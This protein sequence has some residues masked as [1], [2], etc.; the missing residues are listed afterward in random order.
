[1]IAWG[2]ED[3]PGWVATDA[4]RALEIARLSEDAG[5]IPILRERLRV[6]IDRGND[7]SPVIEAILLC[8]GDLARD[9]A[10]TPEL[11][12]E[13]VEMARRVNVAQTAG[14]APKKYSAVHADRSRTLQLF[15]AVLDRLTGQQV[16]GAA[17]QRF[18]PE[19]FELVEI[20]EQAFA[21]WL[22]PP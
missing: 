8:L 16:S 6:E 14:G 21:K 4:R 10:W 11:V 18:G 17:V 3:C 1:L 22:N 5:V 15:A 20:D 19:E 2:Q 13:L 9:T 7:S 12:A